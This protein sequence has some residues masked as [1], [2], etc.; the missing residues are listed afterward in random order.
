MLSGETNIRNAIKRIRA[1]RVHV[2]LVALG[3]RG[4]KLET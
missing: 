2:N 3:D 1:R 4:I